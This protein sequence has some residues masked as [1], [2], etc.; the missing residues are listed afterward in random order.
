[1]SAPYA[2]LILAIAAVAALLAMLRVLRHAGR[3]RV[4]LLLLQPIAAAALA[5]ALLAPHAPGP[6]RVQV[7]TEGADDV[8]AVEGAAT[9]RLP[10]APAHPGVPTW[11]D[12]ATL[13]RTHPQIDTLVLHGHG[14]DQAALS[15]AG[16]R[17]IVFE[18]APAPRGIIALDAPLQVRPGA[19]FRIRGQV[20]ADGETTLQLLDP[21]GGVHAQATPDQEGRFALDAIAPVSG[22]HTF[23]L[24]LLAD[25]EPVHTVPIAVSATGPLPQ[26]GLLFAGAPSAELRALRRWAADAGIA[27]DARITLAPGLPLQDE[28]VRLD[29]ATLAAADLL[30][31]DER[32]WPD[33]AADRATLRN[34]L[35]EGL[36]VLLQV[37]GPLPPRILQ[38]LAAW[39]AN[40]G[41]AEG[42][43][44]TAQPPLILDASGETPEPVRYAVRSHPPSPAPAG[45]RATES[46]AEP[47]ELH[48]WPIRFAP[49]AAPLLTATDGRLLGAWRPVGLGRLGVLALADSHRLQALASEAEYATL[50][51]QLWTQLARGSDAMPLSVAPLPLPGERSLVCGGEGALAADAPDGTTDLLLRDPAAE[52]CAAWYPRAAGWHRLSAGT[53]AIDVH[54][55]DA[56][57]FAPIHRERRRNATLEAAQHARTDGAPTGAPW[58]WRSLLPG[59]ALLLLAT[60]WWLER[61]SP[62]GTSAG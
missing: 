24:E 18:A 38:D 21:A 26:T 44:S 5:A 60:S 48:A 4:P 37:T 54:V 39:A 57:P 10:A 23:A 56:A 15:A 29:A 33:N 45:P 50:W 25:G 28:P 9:V 31:L 46:I 8:V 19:V 34:A 43:A 1:M 58:P 22:R 20:R 32:S 52:Q 41:S 61:R 3:H 14:L 6:Q 30:L 2:W 55:A 49:A 27:L 59:L 16:D 7:L 51:S 11:P 17:H 36:G 40:G 12:L 53:E 47:V 42:G 35:A 62:G 13:L